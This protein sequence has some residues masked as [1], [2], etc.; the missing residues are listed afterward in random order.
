MEEAAARLKA[1]AAKAEAASHAE[2]AAAV[3]A[4]EAKA[5]VEKVEKARA[6]AEEERA[7]RQASTQARG[8]HQGC[9]LYAQGANNNFP[10]DIAT[11]IPGNYFTPEYTLSPREKNKRLP[12]EYGRWPQDKQLAWINENTSYVLLPGLVADTDTNKVA[13]FEKLH[14]PT[15]TRI[16]V[17]FN[18]N[19]TRIMTIE[20]ADAKIREQTGRSLADWSGLASFDRG[21]KLFLDSKYEE[22]IKVYRAALKEK[23]DDKRGPDALFLVG[24]AYERLGKSAE[25]MKVYDELIAKFPDHPVAG[26]A[27]KRREAPTTKPTAPSGG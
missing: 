13:I 27:R 23:P 21:D 17:V 26:E 20:E 15:L 9:I 16:P 4:A 2:A 25:A 3:A 7:L 22:A 14:T 8:I 11:M 18:D 6:A 12:D 19:S 5:M 10:P 24:K 1:E